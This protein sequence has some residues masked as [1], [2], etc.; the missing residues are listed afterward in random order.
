VRIAPGSV[1]QASISRADSGH[2]SIS[3][4]KEWAKGVRWRDANLQQFDAAAVIRRGQDHPIDGGRQVRARSGCRR[5][6]H[7]DA[8]GPR[9]KHREPKRGR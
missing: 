3:R 8:P 9:Q 7:K 5:E 4:A 1:G 2:F 6:C